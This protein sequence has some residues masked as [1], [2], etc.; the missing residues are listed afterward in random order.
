MCFQTKEVF[1]KKNLGTGNKKNAIM[2]LNVRKSRSSMMA[3]KLSS[4]R[5]CCWILPWVCLGALSLLII[6][7]RWWPSYQNCCAEIDKATGIVNFHNC[8]D[9]ELLHATL[10]RGEKPSTQLYESTTRIYTGKLEDACNGNIT[11]SEQWP[12]IGCTFGNMVDWLLFFKRMSLAD[13]LWLSAAVCIVMV[14]L[15]LVCALLMVLARCKKARMRQFVTYPSRTAPNVSGYTLT[16]Q[17]PETGTSDNPSWETQ[18]AEL[19]SSRQR[20]GLT[21]SAP[22]EQQQESDEQQEGQTN[23]STLVRRNV[24]SIHVE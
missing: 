21:R 17:W 5:M 22:P 11:K 16:T 13:V 3:E 2:R 6:V 18:A 10:K 4:Q 1:N 19:P 12:L 20:E 7:I 23:G 14:P 9:L 8:H 24:T 15:F